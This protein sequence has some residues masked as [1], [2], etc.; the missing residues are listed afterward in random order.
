[1][2]KWVV[3]TGRKSRRCR[4]PTTTVTRTKCNTSS[5]LPFAT[6]TRIGSFNGTGLSQACFT[7]SALINES[8]ALESSSAKWV[9]PFRNS[10][11]K[12]NG[13]GGG[14]SG[15]FSLMSDAVSQDSAEIWHTDV[16][17]SCGSP[18][19]SCVG[20]WLIAKRVLGSDAWLRRVT[21]S[22]DETAVLDF[23]LFPVTFV[24][25]SED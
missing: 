12:S 4:V 24:V 6:L 7:T 20:L 21:L 23:C 14:G 10:G 3:N 13:I 8:D 9:V 25:S 5:D 16:Q 19:R 22:Q 18:K 17:E 15:P 11:R 1:M 2:G